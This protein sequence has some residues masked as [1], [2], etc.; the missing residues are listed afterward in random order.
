M[1]PYPPVTRATFPSSLNNA[2]DRCHSRV[3]SSPVLR[4]LCADPFL[5]E[6]RAHRIVGMG[7]QG[8]NSNLQVREQRQRNER[9]VQLV[10]IVRS[11]DAPVL[12]P[13]RHAPK[14]DQY[15]LPRQ[16][17]AARRLFSRN[18]FSRS[19]PAV[20]AADFHVHKKLHCYLLRLTAIFTVTASKRRVSSIN[21][22]GRGK[23]GTL[24]NRGGREF[25]CQELRP[26][27]P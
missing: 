10:A 5:V 27:R 25:S 16:L 22:R 13:P 14:T 11:P 26:W 8:M 3:N 21:L 18:C 19:S 24:Q 9:I 17:T 6:A 23:K 1:P 2:S 12:P 15:S 7:R 20:Y 4:Y